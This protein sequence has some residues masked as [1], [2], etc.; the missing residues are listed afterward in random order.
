MN[1]GGGNPPPVAMA[2][3]GRAPGFASVS[4][5]EAND[6]PCR[7]ITSIDQNSVQLYRASI[8]IRAEI[9]SLIMYVKYTR[10]KKKR[11]CIILSLIVFLG[12][13]ACRLVWLVRIS[14]LR[15]L[16]KLNYKFRYALSY[17]LGRELVSGSWGAKRNRKLR[18]SLDK[19][20]LYSRCVNL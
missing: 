17:S 6:A 5:S 11:I 1:K 3:V 4:N 18:L 8:I 10:Q 2:T 20:T 19:D 14:E 15:E 7:S 9:I 13:A 12:F 16:E